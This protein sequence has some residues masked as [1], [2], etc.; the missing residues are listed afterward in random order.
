MKTF[1]NIINF[2]AMPIGL[3][4]MILYIYWCFFTNVL[5]GDNNTDWWYLHICVA[6]PCL[7][8]GPASIV[9]WFNNRALRKQA[10]DSHNPFSE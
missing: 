9:W 4:M 5:D 10:K 8:F 7:G 6:I 1:L 3:V 2:M